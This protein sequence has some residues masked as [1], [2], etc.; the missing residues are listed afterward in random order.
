[1]RIERA[2]AGFKRRDAGAGDLGLNVGL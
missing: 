1:V 2:D